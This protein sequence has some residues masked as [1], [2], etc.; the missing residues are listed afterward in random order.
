MMVSV[1]I[2]ST[3]LNFGHESG[4]QNL[5]DPN[6]DKR[7]FSAFEN[8]KHKTSGMCVFI[9]LTQVEHHISVS[10]RKNLFM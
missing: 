4:G 9:I 7:S 8:K 1:D 10:R 2:L 5:K 6:E 3:P